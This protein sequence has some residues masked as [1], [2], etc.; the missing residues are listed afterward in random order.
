MNVNFNGYNEGVATFVADS[1]IENTNTAVVMSDGGTVALCT[2][3]KFCGIC[4]GL[5]NGY[6]A[7]QLSGYVNMPAATEI[8]PGYKKLVISDGKIAEGNNGREYLVV[9][10]TADSIGFML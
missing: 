10:S 9:E 7:V 1:S 3:G 6:A 4:V 8:M 2:E 5:R